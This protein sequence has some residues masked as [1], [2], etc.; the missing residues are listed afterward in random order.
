VDAV[1]K[2]LVFFE[3]LSPEQRDLFTE[4]CAASAAP[5]VDPM[6]V[7]PSLFGSAPSGETVATETKFYTDGAGS[8]THAEH[9]LLAA[10]LVLHF[11]SDHRRLRQWVLDA[12]S[13]AERLGQLGLDRV[14]WAPPKK[15]LWGTNGAIIGPLNKAVAMRA[16]AQ[17]R[18]I[19]TQPTEAGS[20]GRIAT[21][22]ARSPRGMSRPSRRW[23]PC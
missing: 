4:L 9:V 2:S 11:D 5:P 21:C 8:A 22:T 13:D 19:E 12:E 1:A 10:L 3:S 20:L 15:R 16:G 18:V 7:E 17:C 6:A 14:V 23:Q